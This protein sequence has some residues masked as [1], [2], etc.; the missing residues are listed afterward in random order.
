MQ[1]IEDVWVDW[2]TTKV[3]NG[4]IGEFL[5]VVRK[6]KGTDK[7][8]L[9]SI[10][11]ENPSLVTINLNFSDT[12]KRYHAKIYKD[13]KDSHDMTHPEVFEI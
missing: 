13:A 11:D 4:E 12:N 8:F 10:T 7:W 3:I 9:G 6:E 5:T 1:F 2:T